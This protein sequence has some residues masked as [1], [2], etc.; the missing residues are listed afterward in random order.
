MSAWV[1]KQ[2]RALR[3]VADCRRQSNGVVSTQI[4]QEYFVT[5]TRELRVPAEL[6]AGKTSIL[7]RLH[8]L[9]PGLDDILAAVDLHRLHGL[10]FWNALVV[11][12]ALV[13]GCVRLLTEDL[14]RGR[15]FDRLEIVNPFAPNRL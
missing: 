6:T 4:L 14:Q 11:R 8:V 5:A 13:S 12:S 15:Q 3:I 2:R 7:G 1:L 10:S 9:P